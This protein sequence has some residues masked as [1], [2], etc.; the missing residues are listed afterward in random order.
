MPFFWVMINGDTSLTVASPDVTI[1]CQFSSTYNVSNKQRSSSKVFAFLSTF[2]TQRQVINYSESDSNSNEDFTLASMNLNKTYLLCFCK[3]W[4]HL[5]KICQRK[6]SD[7]L[8]EL[9]HKKL[10]KEQIMLRIVGS[11]LSS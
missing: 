11:P 10:L 2:G 8:F 1:I 9:A 5:Q 6:I 7:I 4:I 3:F